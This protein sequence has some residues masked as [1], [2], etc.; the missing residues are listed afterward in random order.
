LNT[1]PT[2]EKTFRS[3]PEHAGHSVREPS[4]KDC[5]ASNLWLQVVQAY[6]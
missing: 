4:A 5:T 6:W 1:I 2:D 3:D